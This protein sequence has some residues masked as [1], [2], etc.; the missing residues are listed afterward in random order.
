MAS[1]SQRVKILL[2]AAIF[3]CYFTYSLSYAVIGP[4]RLDLA[5]L[6]GSDFEHA[7]YGS[8]TRSAGNCIG[9]LLFGW[10]FQKMNRQ[11]GFAACLCTCGMAML[12]TPFTGSL[13]LYLC[14]EML[15]GLMGSGIDVTINCW[16]LEIWKQDANPHMQ[17]TF[18]SYA[19]GG[20]VSPLLVESFL[21]PEAMREM[22]ETDI[23][24][25]SNDTQNIM[26]MESKI[27]I[28]YSAASAFMILAAALMIIL[29]FKL[30]YNDPKRKIKDR[31]SEVQ[32]KNPTTLYA[33]IKYKRYYITMIMLGSLLECCYNG[34]E[35]TTF[36]FFPE[37]VH[38]MDLKL[39]TAAAAVITSAMSGAFAVNMLISILIATK[40][41]AKVMLFISFF[42]IAVGN[43]ILLLFANKSVTLLWTAAVIIGSGHSCVNPCIMS[44]LEERMNARQLSVASSCSP[45]MFPP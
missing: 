32:T 3:Y 5:H 30:P 18:L 14:T 9:A 41:P 29:L 24:T 39:T 10:L 16:V 40:I 19:I 22:N 43:L 34:I 1:L 20:T 28:P 17:A 23:L 11:L 2:T 27:W 15:F 12:V 21:S 25:Q 36:A 45:L 33:S 8:V 6:I 38:V 37:F 35:L 31:G 7:S 13:W 26:S 44:F 4:A 42:M